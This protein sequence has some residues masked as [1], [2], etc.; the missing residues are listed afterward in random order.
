MYEFFDALLIDLQKLKTLWIT[1]EEDSDEFYAILE[2]IEKYVS[3][4]AID[5][6]LVGKMSKSNEEEE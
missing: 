2:N 4:K 3:K 1:G 6:G 5:L